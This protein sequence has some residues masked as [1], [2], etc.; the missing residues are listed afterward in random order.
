VRWLWVVL[1]IGCAREAR[2]VEVPE[3][4][5]QTPLVPGIPGSPGHFVVTEV[6][7]DGASE[8]A[9]LMRGFVDDLREARAAIQAGRAV[10]PRW[11]VHRR[12]RCAWPT[13]LAERDARFDALAV[14]YL[15][16][17]RAL[18]T[19][20]TAT[21]FNRVLSG[22]LACHETMCPGP[23]ELIEGLRLP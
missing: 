18:D 7:P 3:C 8:L 1:F 6:H 23:I 17:L 22:C 15:E 5:G 9:L 20:P 16:Q 14:A 10:P 4:T 2:P 21:T 13:S 11:S 12:M 19:H